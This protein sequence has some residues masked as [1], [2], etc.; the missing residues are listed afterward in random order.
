M[1]TAGFAFPLAAATL[2]VAQSCGSSDSYYNVTSKPFTL[3][4]A[5]EDGSVKSSLGA[6]HVGAALE[7]ICLSGSI[8]A[9]K[10]NT[11]DAALFNFNSSIYAQPPEPTFGTPGI[12]T[13]ILHGANFNVSFP[14][15]FSYDP[16]TDIAVP[17][18]GGGS[19]TLLAFD[20]DNKLTVQAYVQNSDQP[21]SNGAYKQYY[22]WYACQTYYASYHYTNLAWGLGAAK[23]ENPTCVAVNVTRTFV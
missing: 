1:R 9:S 20:A 6:C 12:L 18:I 15:S 5:S 11:S 7:S 2:A 17:I 16:T 22:R 23:P 19:P 21:P 13:W 3:Q 4:V 8:S 14:A 10:P